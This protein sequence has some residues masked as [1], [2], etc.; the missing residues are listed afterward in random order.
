MPGLFALDPR[1]S[2]LSEP[3]ARDVER[4][5][6]ALARLV[7]RH[8]AP[9]LAEAAH[10]MVASGEAPESADAELVRELARVFTL[11][12]QLLNLAEQK[13]IVRVNRERSPRGESVAEAAAQVARER[14]DDALRAAA[15][16]T[17]IVPTLT[18][19]PTEAKRKAILDKLQAVSFALDDFDRPPALDARLDAKAGVESRLEALLVELWLTDELREQRLSVQEEVRNA[20]YFFERTI[21][22]V[23]P[24]L[25]EDARRALARH[26]PGGAEPPRIRYRSWVGG[27]RDGNP[28]VT[29]ELSRWTLEQHRA[30]ILARLA[31]DLAD[32]RR[33]LTASERLAHLSPAS[34]EAL[35][36]YD[37][38]LREGVRTRYG[39]EP[40]VRFLLGCEN[41]LAA[42]TERAPGAYAGPGELSA[43]LDRVDAALREAGASELTD[44]GRLPELRER[45]AAFG[46]HLA[47]LDLR[48]HS[49]VHG[50]VVGELMRLGGVVE[51]YAE[52]DEA[53]K[54]E[55]L[56]RELANPRPL[57]PLGAELSDE[58]TEALD[59]MRVVSWAHREIGPEAVRAYI[60]SMT[61]EISDLL[62][63]LLL[64]KE[65][66]LLVAGGAPFDLVPL[67]ETVDD[68][69][70][71]PTLLEEL[72]TEPLYRNLV[73]ARGGMEIMLGYSDSSKDGGYLAANWALQKAIGEIA[74]V[75]ARHAVPLRFFHGRG[76]TVGRGGGRANRA[77]LAQPEG[78][79]GG[80]IRF[81]EQGEVIAFRYALPA[82]AHRH[83]EQIVGACLLAS[84][85]SSAGE[86]PKPEPFA[87]EMAIMA[88]TSRRAYRALVYDDPEFWSF[89]RQATPIEPIALLPIAS[90]PV[91][92]GADALKGIGDLRAIPWNFAWVQSRALVVGWYGVGA[93]LEAFGDPAKLRRMYEE[94]P[95]FRTVL[96]NAQ[97]ELVR[98]D[99]ATFRRYAARVR[100]EAL[101]ARVL[102]AIEEEYDRTARLLLAASGR[103]RLLGDGS[104]VGRT[105]AF[106]NPLTRPLNALQVRALDAWA[107]S[108]ARAPE[109]GHDDPAWREAVL[110]TIAGVA[111]A[112]QSTG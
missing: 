67:F 103:D 68:L 69:E 22:S 52:A 105:V 50:R 89:Y 32:L 2:G 21:L 24:W 28:N 59:T 42:T 26:V 112:M 98:A 44:D 47:A 3:L 109:E 97:L 85:Q 99:M 57:L 91:S 31:A 51:G 63:P 55:A 30:L 48:Q 36:A 83:L 10:A 56:R 94:W 107:E 92:R 9:G 88:A 86:T 29:A 110:Q 34:L 7:A 81:T 38:L 23:V 111:A 35:S 79:F 84:A 20:L 17:E 77:I 95:F 71:A 54:A 27:D 96:D 100:P 108:R 11:A 82:I 39:Q 104:V 5:D 74:A 18:A 70:R 12:F 33:A 58:A 73:E 61:H 43:D 16:R 93:G 14:G 6:A 64:A 40:F 45:V 102:G 53:T 90:R 25:R 75:A 65:A 41:R 80:E 8:G 60:I 78:T 46:F 49:D 76:G 13:E 15:S 72:L 62:E 4:L 101:G 19:H 106:R 1:A 37:G 87:E 66:G